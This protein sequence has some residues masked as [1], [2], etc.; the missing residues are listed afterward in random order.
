M[1]AY[2]WREQ[3]P[4]GQ[5]ERSGRLHQETRLKGLYLKIVHDMAR[6]HK[7][8]NKEHVSKQSAYFL[9]FAVPVAMAV[10]LFLV[11]P[12]LA[13]NTAG[14][15]ITIVLLAITFAVMIP[16]AW[17]SPSLGKR[18]RW[19]LVTVWFAVVS[20]LGIY[21]WPVTLVVSPSELNFNS[22]F[23]DETFTITV[24]NKSDSDIYSADVN[25]RV[26]GSGMGEEFAIGVPSSS[27]KPLGNIGSTGPRL[28]DI[29]GMLCSDTDLAG[30]RGFGV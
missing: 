16:P 17:Q 4:T 25:L 23:D 2:G 26:E 27:R 9:A 6:N 18:R 15:I 8:R 7:A 20:L 1:L 29:S 21:V 3:P 30:G 13:G 22:V 14:R 19:T 24:T 28:S 5:G 10:I 12:K 11:T